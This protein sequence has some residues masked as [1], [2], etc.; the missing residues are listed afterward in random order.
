MDYEPTM[1]ELK[2]IWKR[3]GLWRH[4]HK[5]SDDID[6]PVIRA[7]LRRAAIARHKTTQLPQQGSLE[8]EA[9]HA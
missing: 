5:F 3:S 8:L 2:D 6:V 9:S 4:G 7:T 1:E